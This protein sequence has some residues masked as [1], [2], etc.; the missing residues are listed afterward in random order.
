MRPTGAAVLWHVLIT[1]IGQVVNAVD[2]V[3]DPLLWQIA[4][5][6][7]WLSDESGLGL[8]RGLTAGL[9]SHVV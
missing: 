6:L 1:H 3:P 8:I 4:D 7:E 9:S 5:R 2:V